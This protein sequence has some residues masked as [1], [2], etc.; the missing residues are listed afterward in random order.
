MKCEIVIDKNCEEK[1]VVYSKENNDFIKS[2]KEFVENNESIVGYNGAEIVKIN[3]SEVYCFS[4]INNKVYAITQ[5]EK[6]QLKERLY[7]IEEKLPKNFAK[8]NQSCIVNIDRIKK[9]DASISGTLKVY[10]KNG[11]TDYVSRRQLKSIKEKIG[12]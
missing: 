1:V 2:I 5:K 8:I 9:F 4:V 11:Y 3:F 12:I 6:L 7:T 10:L